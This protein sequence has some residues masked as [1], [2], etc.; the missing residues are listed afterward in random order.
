MD[1][2][3][4]LHQQR[5]YYQYRIMQLKQ[6]SADHLVDQEMSERTQDHLCCHGFV[7]QIIL[8]ESHPAG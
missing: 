7:N 8:Y 3:Q 6:Q 1:R 4:I 2:S 5:Y